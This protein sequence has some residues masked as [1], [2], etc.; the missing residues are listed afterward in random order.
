MA[1]KR[2]SYRECPVA[3]VGMGGRFPGSLDPQ[4]LWKAVLEGKWLG[5]PPPSGRWCLKPESITRSEGIHPDKVRSAVV[6]ATEI[7]PPPPGSHPSWSDPPVRLALEAGCAAWKS[8]KTE[9]LDPGRVGVILGNIVLPTEASGARAESVY[10][11]R[12]GWGGPVGT[13]TQAQPW[14]GLTT[15]LPAAALAA[16]LGLRGGHQTLDAAC[17]SSLYALHL[18]SMELM[19]GRLDAVLAGGVSCPDSLYTQMGFSQLRALSPTGRSRPFDREADGLIV[20]EGAGIFVLKRLRDAMAAGDEILGVI[21]GLGVGNDIEGGLL[22]PSSEGQLRAMTLAYKSAGLVSGDVDFFECHATGAPVGDRV[23]LETL[24]QLLGPREPDRRIPIGSVKAN[25][26]HLL[27]AAG[28]AAIAKMIGALGAKRLPPMPGTRGDEKDFA[29]P[30][31]PVQLLETD[32]PWLTPQGRPRRAGISAFGFGGINAHLLLEE[33]P[34]SGRAV[35]LPESSPQEPVLEPV[36]GIAGWERA[37]PDQGERSG[38]TESGQV[39]T[40]QVPANRFRIPPVEVQALLP[41]QIWALEAAKSLGETLGW[42]GDQPQTAVILQASLDPATTNHHLRWVTLAKGLETPSSLPPLDANKVMGSLASIAASRIARQWKL[43]GPCF[44]VASGPGGVSEAWRIAQGLLATG[45]V[46]RV[47]VG[48][49]ASPAD[50]RVDPESRVDAGGAVLFCLERENPPPERHRPFL[51]RL[52]STG[53][54]GFSP[55][56]TSAKSAQESLE[57]AL[58]NGFGAASIHPDETTWLGYSGSDQELA[59]TVSR[60]LEEFFGPR[61]RPRMRFLDQA[62]C[63]E[64]H[65]SH[66]F[67]PAWIA[68]ARVVEAM[69]SGRFLP[70][71]GIRA[72]SATPEVPGAMVPTVAVPWLVDR[73]NHPRAAAI[74]SVGRDGNASIFLLREVAKPASADPIPTVDWPESLFLIESDQTEG[75]SKGL[76]ELSLL[77]QSQDFPTGRALAR[78]WAQN[79]ASRPQAK[80]GLALTFWG[81]P[82]GE[83][84]DR[85]AQV[86]AL[87]RDL[88][89]GRADGFLACPWGEAHFQKNPL[90]QQAGVCLVYPGSGQAMADMGRR[91]ALAFPDVLEAQAALTARAQAQYVP[92]KYWTGNPAD[93][94]TANHREQILA[95]ISHGCLVTAILGSL[96]LEPAFALGQSLG[97]STMMFAL[98]AWPQRDRMLGELMSSSLFSKDV[99]KPWDAVRQAWKIPAEEEVDWSQA[100]FPLPLHTIR[101][102]IRP[103]EKVCPLI[104]LS[105]QW[106]LVGGLKEKVA[107]LATRLGTEPIWL[108]GGVSVHGPMATPISRAWRSLHHGPVTLV[109]G[110]RMFLAGCPAAMPPIADVVADAFVEAAVGTISFVELVRRAYGAGA[111]VFLEI[112]PGSSCSGFLASILGSNPHR[113]VAIAARPDQERSGLVSAL[114]RLF[115]DR[116]PLGRDS[117]SRLLTLPEFDLTEKKPPMGPVVTIAHGFPF[118]GESAASPIRE[119]APPPVSVETKDLRSLLLA[120]SEPVPSPSIGEPPPP[121]P[122]G[123]DSPLTRAVKVGLLEHEVQSAFLR[124]A[125]TGEELLTR[126]HEMAGWVGE[127]GQT[128]ATREIDEEVPPVRRSLDRPQCMDFAIGKVGNA[129][130]TQF[131]LADQFPTRVRLPDEPLMLVDRVLSIEGEPQSLKSGRVITEH[132]VLQGGWYLDQGRMPISLTVEAGQAD[133]LLA[134]WLG[135][136]FQTRGEAM[137]RL[138]DATITFEGPLP[139]PGEVIRY[140]IRVLRFFRH[141]ESWL[142]R[143]EYDATVGGRPLLRMREGCAGFFT[144]EALAAGKGLLERDFPPMG[145]DRPGISQALD[146][147]RL[148]KLRD[149]NLAGAFGWSDYQGPV[150]PATLPSGRMALFD[151]VTQLDPSGGHAGLGRIATEDDIHPDDWFLVC[152]FIDD[153]VMPGTLMYEACLQSLRVLLLSKGWVV[154]EG[155]VTFEALPG[156]ESSLK[157]RGQ[158][159]A[160]TKVARY[161]VEIAEV[162]LGEN[163]SVVAHAV[164]YAD[165]KPVVSVRS[166]SLMLLG[167]DSRKFPSLNPSPGSHVPSRSPSGAAYPV[168]PRVA[169]PGL[170]MDHPRLLEF[171][172]GKPSLAFGPLFEPFDQ[173][174][175]MARLPRPPYLFMDDVVEFSGE[176]LTQTAPK[177]CVA[178][179]Q[180]KPG[181]WWDK[182]SGHGRIPFAVLLEIALQ[183][184]GWISAQSGAA[185]T[186]QEDLSYRNLGGVGHLRAD[187]V[188][189]DGLIEVRSKLERISRS[190]GMILHFFSFDVRMDGAPLYDGTT[191]FGFFTKAAL[192]NQ[193]GITDAKLWQS[194]RAP[195]A[196]PASTFPTLPRPPLLMLDEVIHLEPQGGPQGLGFAQG[197]K[198]VDP[199]EWFFQAHFY[200]DPVMPGSLGLEAF[201]QLGSLLVESGPGPVLLEPGASSHQW[202]YRGQ[203]IGSHRT[204]GTRVEVVERSPGKI[205]ANGFVEVDGRVIYSMEKFSLKRSV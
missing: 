16:S 111:R 180:V 198:A 34:G 28:S 58:E 59:G 188:V 108:P 31:C 109:P 57:T 160:T 197:A 101:V 113:A 4:G 116:I 46:D 119:D 18:A 66:D 122:D 130:G 128:I 78:A 52:L 139:T 125:R 82:P 102:G 154:A 7:P 23:E 90:G 134:G 143:F 68:L 151:R 32:R 118:P 13:A 41:Q 61:V 120:R 91:L 199:K 190:A 176:P 165:G 49:T 132:D 36:L 133:M 106:N 157:C 138:L 159:I 203:V 50:P 25:I 11:A 141:G 167:G 107:E 27:T 184:C 92:C 136:D 158:V 183:P 17:A 187:P 54:A 129:L 169:D 39:G 164:M 93:A 112:G 2:I 35:S 6:C 175:V 144:P 156:V 75:L 9:R 55:F 174:R 192:G 70:Q 152:H 26:G 72:S 62:G 127:G 71:P 42:E 121:F 95:Q 45:E 20:G 173:G 185:L 179:F 163:P 193:V 21:A 131:A 84:G 74:A 12:G 79:Q 10:G 186:S 172:T 104:E 181:D 33:P 77:A 96:G 124:F 137:Y 97:E 98:G 94:T 87:G 53:L 30:R 105:P 115:A 73:E 43:G 146:A 103:G 63:Q 166:M 69:E 205:V 150:H 29:D 19:L 5:A 168:S 178:R 202:V 155:S 44:T 145:P 171:C 48:A 38:E 123:P 40:I 22:A 117:L 88:L 81:G 135:I 196:R 56:E 200:Q 64:T 86:I 110:M 1:A 170:P 100:L 195:L 15:V 51:A 191:Y 85:F 149:G 37:G 60:Q 3:I 67:L 126:I 89:A 189:R 114:A 194:P 65:P 177:E 162:R 76:E 47:I 99:V 80:L 24:S 140:D 153:Q 161:E 83:I 147:A 148:Q 142:F 204:I 8:A 14:D 201:L 182:A